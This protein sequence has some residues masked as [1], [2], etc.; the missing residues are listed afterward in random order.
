MS[1]FQNYNGPIIDVWANWWGNNFFVKFPRFKELYERIGI[2]QRMA[3]SSKSLLMEAKRQK[4]VK[5][6]YRPQF[7]M[8]RWLQMRKF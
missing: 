2:E 6:F 1:E 3:N 8:K 4:L 5:L 7:L